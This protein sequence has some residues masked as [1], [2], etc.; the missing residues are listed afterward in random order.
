[1]LLWRPISSIEKCLR[2]ITLI[3]PKN[4][5]T[6]PTNARYLPNSLTFIIGKLCHKIQ[7]AARYF[8]SETLF[9]GV[10]ACTYKLCKLMILTAFRLTD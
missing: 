7:K 5:H 4:Y 9:E 2:P 8:G 10:Q 6:N 1:M 3:T